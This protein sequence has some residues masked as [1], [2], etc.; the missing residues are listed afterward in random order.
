MLQHLINHV[1]LVV[2]ADKGMH[3]L[4]VYLVGV[5][6]SL[7]V[8]G[9]VKLVSRGETLLIKYLRVGLVKAVDDGD[10]GRHFALTGP[11]F[12]QECLN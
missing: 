2:F 4:C 12:G 8:F 5:V 6:E 9:L 3:E 11:S 1:F 7:H 10:L